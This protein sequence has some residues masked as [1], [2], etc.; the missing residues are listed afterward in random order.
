MKDVAQLVQNDIT[1]GTWFVADDESDATFFPQVHASS[2]LISVQEIYW[3][4]IAVF[5]VTSCRC[6]PNAHHVLYTTVKDIPIVDGFNFSSFFQE[7]GVEVVRLPITYRLPANS[8]SSWGNQF[9]ILD[10]IKHFANSDGR[11][12][13]VLDSDCVWSRPADGLIASIDRFGALTY[14]LDHGPT[15][16]INGSSRV[17]MAA[18]VRAMSDNVVVNEPPQYFGGEIYAADRAASAS[19][20]RQIDR[21]W[22]LTI[23]RAFQT[24]FIKEEAHFLSVLY[25][26]DRYKPGTANDFIKRMWTTFK[27]NNLIDNDVNIPIWHVPA[28]KKFGIRR[29]FSDLSHDSCLMDRKSSVE[30]Y[31]YLSRRLGIPSR[32][33]AKFISDVSAKLAERLL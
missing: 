23:E 19:M 26:L 29:I 20:A 32:G 15:E 16:P 10:I 3:K 8:V 31:S 7:K 14:S 17:E 12:L 18:A 4:C 5:F 22:R 25:T 2:A 28:E 13:V 24:G 1:I 11:R 9:Y 6:N 27:Y 21:L 33:P 30:Y